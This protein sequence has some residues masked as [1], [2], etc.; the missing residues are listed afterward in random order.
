M[1]RIF[2]GSAHK[3]TATAAAQFTPPP[4]VTDTIAE[5]LAVEAAKIA[6]HDR[7]RETSRKV[8]R[9]IPQCPLNDN[10]V[11][12]RI[13]NPVEQ[14]LS[15]VRKGF[16]ISKNAGS[17]LQRL[18]NAI[19]NGCS[20]KRF[21]EAVCRAGRSLSGK[22]GVPKLTTANPLIKKITE[23]YTKERYA[24]TAGR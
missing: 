5:P 8:L 3:A 20:G 22:T 24:V 7:I 23:R 16:T 14:I 2:S 11:E 10:N 13:G 17:F 12:I 1:E 4:A 9:E 21:R 6:I 18:R 19:C 15:T